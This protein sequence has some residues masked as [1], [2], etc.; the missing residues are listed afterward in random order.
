MNIGR[1]RG[2]C[3]A[4]GAS[5]ETHVEGGFFFWGKVLI[6]DIGS[7]DGIVPSVS[8]SI[9]L[10]TQDLYLKATMI[11]RACKDLNGSSFRQIW[12]DRVDLWGCG[13]FFLSIT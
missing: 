3:R 2:Q 13:R 8:P 10:G 4:D 9:V 6:L 7:V 11:C 5:V 1:F 12:R